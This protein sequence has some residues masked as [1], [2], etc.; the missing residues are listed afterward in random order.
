MPLISLLDSNQMVH[1]RG[2]L[3]WGFSNAHVR[4]YDAYIPIPIKTIR[5][6]LDL[7]KNRGQR[8]TILRFI[9]DD[10]SQMLGRFEGTR[11]NKED[12]LM[13]PKQIASYPHKSILGQYFRKRLNVQENRR[14]TM[15]DLTIY[16]R[17]DI[18]ITQIGINTYRIDFSV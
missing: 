3:N 4:R 12:G 18:D 7:F 13:Y 6:N 10:G 9:W 14:I 16:G 15:N 1:L 5:E 11:I 17:M 8:N 2:G